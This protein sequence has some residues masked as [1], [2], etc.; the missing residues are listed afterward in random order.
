MALR[1]AWFWA[2][3][4]ALC[5]HAQVQADG[6]AAQ[7]TS[8]AYSGTPALAPALAM[9]S[10]VQCF[11]AGFIVYLVVQALGALRRLRS[12]FNAVRRS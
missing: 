9:E 8:A 5:V 7:T 11:L 6:G 12:D 10:F 4:I 2:C 1:T 3:S